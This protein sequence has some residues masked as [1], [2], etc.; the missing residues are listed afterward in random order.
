MFQ[1][2]KRRGPRN[3]W[4]DDYTYKRILG[5]LNDYWIDEPEEAV[6]KIDM[7]FEHANG[8]TQE[9]SLTWRNPELVKE[10]RNNATDF[11]PLRTI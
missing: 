1:H 9:K 8:E 6:V 3:Y 10:Q 7:Y 11:R 5:I 4:K 2:S